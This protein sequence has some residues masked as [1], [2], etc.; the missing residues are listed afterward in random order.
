M[1]E[2]PVFVKIE[3]YKDALDLLEL[4][5]AKVEQSKEVLGKINELKNQEDEELDAWKSSLDEIDRK[6]SEID[7]SLLAPEGV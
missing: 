1:S 7:N 6:I 5:K 4:I 3:E 2:M